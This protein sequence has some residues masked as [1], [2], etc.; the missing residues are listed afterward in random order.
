MII[1]SSGLVICLKDVKGYI[2]GFGL[3]EVLVYKNKC[4]DNMNIIF[5]YDEFCF[6][7][8]LEIIFRDLFRNKYLVFCR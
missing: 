2:E 4:L 6:K 7:L 8:F 1:E 3:D 5:I